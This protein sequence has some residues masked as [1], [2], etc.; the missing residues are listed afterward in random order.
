MNEKLL[1]DPMDNVMDDWSVERRIAHLERSMAVRDAVLMERLTNMSAKLEDLTTKPNWI[2]IILGAITIL[3][4][5][6]G[7]INQAFISPL[8]YRVTQLEKEVEDVERELDRRQAYIDDHN[9]K[10]GLPSNENM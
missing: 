9:R 10:L 3:G 5:F 4:F 8:D 1:G 2:A 6:G 7:L